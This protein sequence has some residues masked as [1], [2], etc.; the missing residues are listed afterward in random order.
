[1]P[2]L[3]QTSISC[4]ETFCTHVHIHDIHREDLCVSAGDMNTNCGGSS[5]EVGD[6]REHPS[7]FEGADQDL[8]M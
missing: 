2:S 7:T 6:I 8:P 3:A 1:M 5:T 4:I